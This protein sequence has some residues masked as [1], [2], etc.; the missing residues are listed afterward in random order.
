M[1]SLPRRF[2][3]FSLVEADHGFCDWYSAVVA[4]ESTQRLRLGATSTKLD[5]DVAAINQSIKVYLANGG[6]LDGTTSPAAV[7]EKLK[8]RR[9]EPTPQ[10]LPDFDPI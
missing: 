8:T 10:R 6:T 2:R 5:S 3:A 4:F 7:L 9:K 1:A